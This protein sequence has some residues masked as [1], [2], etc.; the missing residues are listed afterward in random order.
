M[1]KE[2]QAR[3]WL[4]SDTA[5]LIYIALARFVIHLLTNGGYGIAT[6]TGVT[7]TIRR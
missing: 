1:P 7:W 3:H 5:I 2:T 4:L 6:W